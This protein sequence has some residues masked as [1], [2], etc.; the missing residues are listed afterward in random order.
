MSETSKKMTV[1]QAI[2]DRRS[3]R[4][5]KSDKLTRQQVE[6]LISSACAAPSGKNMQPWEFIV[7]IDEQERTRVCNAMEQGL[8]RI[9]K[10]YSAV[11]KHGVI[12][13]A[14]NTLSIMRKAPVTVFVFSPGI[15]HIGMQRD[16]AETMH[17]LA[18]VQS[19]GA[20]I[21]NMLLSALE[22]GLGSLWICDVYLA[23]EELVKYFG[24]DSLMVAAVSLGVP[25]ESPVMRP[26]KPTEE[27]IQWR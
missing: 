14:R 22:I 26:R 16:L 18:S 7:V 2:K 23:Y 21:Q 11:M 5:F 25:D 13:G 27:L 8:D 6:F 4:K 12:Y 24:K 3:I 10:E 1:T 19:I 17:D 9:E 20:A 15:P